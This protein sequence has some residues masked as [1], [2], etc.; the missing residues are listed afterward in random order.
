[1][2]YGRYVMTDLTPDSYNFKMEM[3]EDNKTWNTMMEGKA[4][5]A[6]AKPA[7]KK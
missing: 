7:E 4:T 2:M 1:M 5:K 6:A 3:S